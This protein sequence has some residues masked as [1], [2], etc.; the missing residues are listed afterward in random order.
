V[1]YS[2]ILIFA[3]ICAV[4]TGQSFK[5]HRVRMQFKRDQ[6]GFKN[7]YEVANGTAAVVG[8]SGGRSSIPIETR[9]R[10]TSNED[11]ASLLSNSRDHML[12]NQTIGARSNKDTIYQYMPSN[13]HV[14]EDDSDDDSNIPDVPIISR[15]SHQ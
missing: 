4:I 11:G 12:I 10:A 1:S 6:E 7:A 8:L 15:E 3:M 14:A 2:L 13:A 9:P 5:Y